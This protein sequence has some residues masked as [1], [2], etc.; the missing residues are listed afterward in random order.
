MHEIDSKLIEGLWNPEAPP[1]PIPSEP[2]PFYQRSRRADHGKE[3]L[4]S[5]FTLDLW[6]NLADL[7]AGQILLAS[8][9][10]SLRTVAG[11]AVELALTDGRTEN[12]WASDPG[13]IS[14]GKPQHIV[15]IVD[16]GPK[17]ISFVING[18]LNDGGE[19]RQ[20]GWGRFSPNLKGVAGLQEIKRSPA[21]QHLRV[22]DR[23]LRTAE[24]IANYRAESPR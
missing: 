12:R 13:S 5:G 15:A 4:R 18:R 10:V 16:G 22:Y 2:K 8:A 3:D 9:G 17:I 14:A 21:V 19:A 24:V 11:G 23:Y 6:V 7:R 20:F 1:A